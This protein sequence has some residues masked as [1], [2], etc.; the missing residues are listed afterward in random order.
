M[1]RPPWRPPPP[2]A[3]PRSLDDVSEAIQYVARQLHVAQQEVQT[4]LTRLVHRIGRNPPTTEDITESVID[5]LKPYFDYIDQRFHGLHR[6]I[7]EM[8][9]T[10]TAAYENLKTR[11][12]ALTTEKDAV[13]AFI[14]GVPDLIKHAVEDAQGKG[15]TPE[16]LAAFD[17]LAD[18]IQSD[19]DAMAAA[20]SANTPSA[21][22]AEPPPA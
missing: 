14:E 12:E 4:T 20:V 3:P 7:K 19:R 2:P 17:A 21:P 11:V 10:V 6:E 22:P 8:S 18:T 15:A 9:E 1:A 16:Q 13:V 5:A